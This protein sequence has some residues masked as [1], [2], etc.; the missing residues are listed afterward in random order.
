[1]GL[2]AT[3]IYHLYDKNRYVNQRNN[4]YIRDSAALADAIRDS[5][6]KFYAETVGR[7]DVRL[8]STRSNMDSL[9]GQLDTRVL[10]INSLRTEISDILSKRNITKSELNNARDKINELR[11]RIDELREHS[12][13]LEK[14][15]TRLDSTL[16]LLTHQIQDLEHNVSTLESQNKQLNEIVTNA[17]TLTASDVKVAAIDVKANHIREVETDLARKAD[18]FVVSMFLQNGVTDL[19]HTMIVVMLT[20]PE[21]RVITNPVWES[22][23]FDTK[24]EGRQ[25]YTR[26]V[27]FDYTRSEQKRI[28][29]SLD[30]DQFTKGTY[31]LK[32]Y[33]N[34]VRIGEASTTLR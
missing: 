29:F 27:K 16:S 12:T 30:Y 19:P 24:N 32:V 28:I 1:M 11:A 9:K 7:L 23:Y 13:S 4:V 17:Y 25:P 2:T 3:W 31:Q 18:K 15:K 10:Q 8:D 34:G 6:Q 14:D 33:H 22:D 5:L 20:D 21:G 26:T